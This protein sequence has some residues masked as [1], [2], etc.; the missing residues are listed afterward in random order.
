MA[1]GHRE[2]GKSLTGASTVRACGR[3]GDPREIAARDT[4]APRRVLLLTRDEYTEK[5]DITKITKAVGVFDVQKL[6]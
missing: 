5:F 6:E 1:E 4:S 2:S 3:S